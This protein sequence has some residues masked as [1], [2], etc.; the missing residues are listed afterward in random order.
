MPLNVCDNFLHQ[1]TD[2]KYKELQGQRVWLYWK[3]WP[4]LKKI[5]IRS[6]FSNNIYIANIIYVLLEIVLEI[7]NNIYNIKSLIINILI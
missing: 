6:N 1:N 7:L 2:Q 5:S 4:Y 3:V